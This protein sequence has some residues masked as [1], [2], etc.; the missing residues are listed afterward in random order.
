MKETLGFYKGKNVFVT[1]HTGFK[2]SWL[3]RALTLAGANVTGYALEPPTDPS[4]FDICG[5]GR[6]VAGTRG[7]VRDFESLKKASRAARPEIV[8]HLAAQ[9]IVSVGYRCPRETFDVNVMG[10]VNVLEAARQFGARS[11]VVVTT[12]KVYRAD[13]SGTPLG[14]GDP[15]MGDD[16]YSASKSCAEIVSHSYRESYFAGSGVAL[17]TVRA[18]NTIGGG[19]FAPSRVVPECVRAAVAGEAAIIRDPDSVR[20]YQHV[21]DAVFAY[22]LVAERQYTSPA[23]S[24]AYNASP[25]ADACVSTG[26]LARTFCE[27]WGDGARYEVRRQA[28][29]PREVKAL[30]LDNTKIKKTLGFEPRWDIKETV[31]RTVAFYKTHAAG[32]DVRRATDREIEDYYLM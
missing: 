23:L 24:G 25:D 10:T 3:C 5:I 18:G 21:L 8:F 15:L 4:L 11:A 31:R 19:D 12:D 22:L 28:D 9:P 26:E 17:S 1:G 6:D 27:E 14:E 2:G 29:A 30:R 32:G 13:G 20:P 7:D 16:P